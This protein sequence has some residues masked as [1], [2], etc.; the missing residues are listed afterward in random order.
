MNSYTCC[1]KKILGQEGKTVL[2]K[3]VLHSLSRLHVIANNHRALPTRRLL[4]IAA[5]YDTAGVLLHRRGIG[6]AHRPYYGP[7]LDSDVSPVVTERRECQTRPQQMT[8]HSPKI[9]P[10]KQN[11]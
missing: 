5:L 7:T 8:S 3:G 2:T 6:G 4:F 9:D 11:I 1:N 10:L